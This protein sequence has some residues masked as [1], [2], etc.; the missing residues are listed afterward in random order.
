MTRYKIIV[1]P[2]SGRG[3][4]E[5]I[6]PLLAQNLRGL[7]VDFDLVRT[8]GPLHAVALTQQA[9][10]D[11]FDVVVG[12]GG[13]GT[14]NEVINGLMQAQENGHAR[15]VALGVLPAGRGND[16]SFGVGMPADLAAGC[17]V[18]AAG[19]RKPIDVGWVQGGI[20]PDGRYFGNSI[21]IGFDAVVSIEALK[22][23]RLTGFVSYLVAVFKTIFLHYQTPHVEIRFDGQVV[24]L[25][26]LMVSIMNGRR[27]G[28]AFLMSPQGK[29]DDGL[30]DVC[31]AEKVSR[32][33]ILT[34][35]PHFLKGTQYGQKE[36]RFLQTDQLEVTA[37]QG[38]LPTHCDG[39]I[40]STHSRKLTLALHPR[41]ID[42]IC[43][44]PEDTGS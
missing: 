12:V 30:F 34:L 9:A 29:N 36:I 22:M 17:R 14:A 33:R 24:T 4:G 5:R 35:V 7:G 40:I 19:W 2:T 26:A 27:Q 31:I 3:N 11:G 25:P 28:G 37:V 39:E 38:V 16:F 13:D 10:N 8:A 23:T 44:Q 32:G 41:Q 18:L 43:P 20:E 15:Q 42:V 6:I 21:G 1:N